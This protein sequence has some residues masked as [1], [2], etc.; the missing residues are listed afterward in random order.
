MH[1]RGKYFAGSMVMLLGGCFVA[2]DLD[3][4]DGNGASSSSSGSGGEGGTGG[5]SVSSSSSSG[6]SSS[7]SGIG[8]SGGGGGGIAC[9]PLIC[10][11]PPP[12]CNTS[13][14]TALDW[15]KRYGPAGSDQTALSIKVKPG[16]GGVEDILIAGTYTVTTGQLFDIAG[17]P[18]SAPQGFTGFVAQ[19]SSTMP[20]TARWAMSKDPGEIG[21]VTADKEGNVLIAGFKHTP[22]A[23]YF[24]LEKLSS[25]TPPTVLSRKELGGNGFDT[26]AIDADTD[27]DGN[28]YVVGAT[29]GNFIITCP[30]PGMTSVQIPAGMFI[31]KYNSAG[32]CQWVETYSIVDKVTPKAIRVD[33]IK[34]RV[35]VTGHFHN[36][37]ANGKGTLPGTVGEKM[38]L[39]GHNADTG[40]ATAIYGYGESVAGGGGAVYPAGLELDSDGMVFVGGQVKGK[41]VFSPDLA[42]NSHTGAF[43]ARIDPASDQRTSTLIAGSPTP[44]QLEGVTGTDIALNGTTLALSG[45]FAGRI[46]VGPNNTVVE[47][48]EPMLSGT[49]RSNTPFLAMYETMNLG[50][51]SFEAFPGHG[52]GFKKGT[53]K[54]DMS[55]MSV[56]LAGGWSKT[57]DFSRG[58][59]NENLLTQ[60]PA[61]TNADVFLAKFLYSNP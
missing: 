31:L 58:T 17:Q 2:Y 7:S 23:D 3:E 1:S 20:V 60:D 36:L 48:P 41:T 49:T 14:C 8:G 32:E 37:L 47:S 22:T 39:V 45:A 38:F 18:L 61:S 43:L 56:V 4:F 9:D 51:R 26:Y 24:I 13:D 5:M 29:T 6:E 46:T 44:G 34:K 16:T 33:S 25:A 35:F 57:L 59:N 15:A 55:T 50:L 28:A 40:A 10:K 53:V 42:N 12:N 11:Y 30:E 52:E 21:S 19:L 54:V 27:S